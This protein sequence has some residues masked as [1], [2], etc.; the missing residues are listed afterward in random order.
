MIRSIMI[1]LIFALLITSCSTPPAPTQAFGAVAAAPTSEPAK[2]ALRTTIITL[3]PEHVEAKVMSAD[4]PAELTIQNNPNCKILLRFKTSSI[5][6]GKLTGARLSLIAKESKSTYPEQD[7]TVSLMNFRVR[8]DAPVD[9]PAYWQCDVPFSEVTLDSG[10]LP[11]DT[12]F[13]WTARDE[14]LLALELNLPTGISLYMMTTSRGKGRQWYSDTAD[15]SSDVPRLILEYTVEDQPPVSQSNESSAAQSSQTFWTANEPNAYVPVKFTSAWSNAPAFYNNL[16]YL[17]VEDT[18]AQKELQILDS[19]G[20]PAFAPLPLGDNP[21]QY[22]LISKSGTLSIVGEGKIRIFK[23]DSQG[24]PSEDGEYE[25]E[26][27]IPTIAP[28]LGPDGSLYLVNDQNIYGLNPD[29]QTLWEVP[30]TDLKTSR[31][32]VGPSGQF[33][34]LIT[35][36]EGLLT[37]NAQTGQFFENELPNQADLKVS[38]DP[39]LHA[40]VVIRYPDPNGNEDGAEIIYVAAN[41]AVSG[42]LARYN[43]RKTVTGQEDSGAIDMA[44][45]WNPLI[46]LWGQPILDQLTPDSNTANPQKKIYVVSVANETGTLNSIDWLTGIATPMTPTLAVGD[47]SYLL[48][49]GNLAMDKDG[50]LFLWNGAGDKGLYVFDSSLSGQLLKLED[51]DTPP[52]AQL[53]FGGDGILY[54]N[55]V[56]AQ[57]TL[58]AVVPQNKFAIAPAGTTRTNPNDGLVYVWIPAGEFQMGCSPSDPECL[59][60]E[61]PRHSVTISHGFWLGQ[62]E[63]TVGAYKAYAEAEG[64]AMPAWPPF[65]NE[66]SK[67]TL[68]MANINWDASK[69][70]CELGAKGRLPT[71]AEW[72]YAVR[73]GSEQARYANL[74]AVAWYL[75]NSNG[76]AHPVGTR[77]PNA[78]GVY[79]GL[80]N[81]SEWV[82]DFYD[83]FYYAK[84]PAVDPPGFAGGSL[85]GD[86]RVFRGGAWRHDAFSNRVSIRSYEIPDKA[87]LDTAGGDLGVRCAWD[88]PE[89]YIL[90]SAVFAPPEPKTVELPPVRVRVTVTRFTI[91]WCDD[92]GSDDTVDIDRLNVWVNGFDRTSD[93]DSG[94]LV[95]IADDTYGLKITSLSTDDEWPM[96]DDGP[97]VFELNDQI[98]LSFSAGQPFDFNL[99]QMKFKT[100]ARDY[101]PTSANE[102]AWADLILTGDQFFGAHSIE[103]SSADFGARYD[104]TIERLP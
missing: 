104:L 1:I 55:E 19:I 65:N 21:G 102:E 52:E 47:K 88:S 7:V 20:N 24:K 78:W 51:N 60:T 62:T 76:A 4:C 17:V 18:N 48:N 58:R 9:D 29:L 2:D 25:V 28:T 74:N 42:V 15:N 11:A 100:Y 16:V 6:E 87:N 10:S 86:T 95:N 75:E 101:D 22:L 12:R 26:G 53:S 34:Y 94:S 84:S 73:A 61:G 64:K 8:S 39:T 63:V 57:P 89:P 3:M 37:I 35:K 103:L 90:S 93:A 91:L 82:A 49:G 56:G 99:A 36:N 23:L 96:C 30:L 70:Y 54:L 13:D 33:V 59:F 27:A 85:R 98:V 81:V 69:A 79:D 68:P 83:D 66:W 5:P 72:E 38:D 40:P 80:G 44:D 32:T 41:S 45:S 77:L 43:N 67:L 92:E 14:C 71:E 46:G 97:Y 50:N 31:V